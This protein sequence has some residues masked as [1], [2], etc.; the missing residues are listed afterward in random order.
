MLEHARELCDLLPRLNIGDDPN[1]EN[2]RQE[3]EG[4]LASLST[5][6]I[7]NDPTVRQGAADDAAA[8]MDKMRAFMGGL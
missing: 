6:A 7:R 3:V 4:K 2:M 5:D 8:I 1:L